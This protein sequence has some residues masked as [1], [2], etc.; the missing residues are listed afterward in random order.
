MAGRGFAGTVPGGRAGE[1]DIV[2]AY[3]GVLTGRGA[4]VTCASC[5]AV[6]ALVPGEGLPFPAPERAHVEIKT[7]TYDPQATS[8]LY[9]ERRTYRPDGTAL[10]GGLWRAVT[11]GA[12]ALAYYYPRR[13]LVVWMW[14]LATLTAAL[15]AALRGGA[16]W[17]RVS[18]GNPD[19][20]RA[21][22]RLVPRDDV[23]RLHHGYL[24]DT[25]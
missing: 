9:L 3:G 13:G 4:A 11:D 2:A 14:D 17:R 22:G 16:R 23:R 21:V 25:I 24:E 19:G 15:T 7:D 6:D 1:R 18:V 12:D 5:R 8:N 20:Y 10:D